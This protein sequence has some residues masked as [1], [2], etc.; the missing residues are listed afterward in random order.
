ML[1]QGTDNTFSIPGTES[2][3]ALDALARTFP[4]VSGTS[5][6]LI[7]VAPDGGDVTEADFEDAV[8]DAATAIAAIPQVS[9]ATSPYSTASGSGI[10]TD[11]SAVIVPIQLSVTTTAVLPSTAD[12]LQAAGVALEAELPAGS[13]VAVGGQLF[14]QSA[15]GISITELLGIAVAFVVLFLTFGSLV[16]AGLPLI[17]AL[18]GVGA[19]LAVVFMATS[20]LTITSTTPLLALMLGLAVGIDYAKG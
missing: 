13:Q 15:A 8:T 14:A 18:L 19:S 5:A 3:E 11:H 9:S 6:Q 20:F 7:A 12:A 10:S 2:Q 1:S 17:T 16:A 4:Q